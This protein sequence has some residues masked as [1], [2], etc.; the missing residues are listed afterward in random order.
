MKCDA[1]LLDQSVLPQKLLVRLSVSVVSMSA[2]HATSHPPINQEEKRT[3]KQ[4]LS[5]WPKLSF[6]SSF[7]LFP[8]FCVGHAPARAPVAA[9]LAG[10][11]LPVRKAPTLWP[12][13][14]GPVAC[15][16]GLR[17]EH[18]RQARQQRGACTWAACTT[19]RPPSLGGTRA[20]G[21]LLGRRAWLASSAPPS[22]L[23]PPAA[24]AVV[25]HK[26]L[27]FRLFRLFLSSLFFSSALSLRFDEKLHASNHARRCEWTRDRGRRTHQCHP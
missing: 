7:L 26:F 15:T 8:S 13:H 22:Y 21:L 14:A 12:V 18:A 25:P 2:V 11:A 10:P 6:P 20:A 5:A 27:F 17:T 3:K 24:T 1:S 16:C 4:Y 9:R 23:I 19:R